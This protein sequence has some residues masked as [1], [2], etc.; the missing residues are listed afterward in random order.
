MS[1]EHKIG[2]ITLFDWK[3]YTNW[4]KHH[5]PGTKRDA[6]QWNKIAQK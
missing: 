2:D 4:L 6:E 3:L 5:Y 1:K